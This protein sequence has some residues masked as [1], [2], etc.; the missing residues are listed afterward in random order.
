MPNVRHYLTPLDLSP[1]EREAVLQRASELKSSRQTP[2][3][4]RLRVGAL[5]FNPSLRTRISWEQAAWAVGGSCQTLNANSDNWAIEMDPN[6]VMDGTTVENIVEAARVLGRYFDIL[7]V[8]SFPGAGAWE[9]E[10]TEP[11]LQA[12]ARYSGTSVVSLEGAMHHP[13]QSLADLLTLRELFGPDLRGLPVVLTWASHP[14]PLPMA[15]PNSFA[16]QMA[17]AGCDLRIVRP[18]GYDLDPELMSHIRQAQSQSG[19]SLQITSD[20]ETGYRGAK[21]VYVK[22]W[23]K[24]GLWSDPVQ[25]REGRSALQDW[26][27]TP[28]WHQKTDQAKLMHCLPTRRNVEL[29][30]DLLDGPHSVVI[31]EAENRLWAQ[32]G[33]LDHLGK[34]LGL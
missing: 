21:A 5:F 17:L 30:G 13:C 12:F 31:D 27:Y 28:Q 15:V 29:S 20:R 34:E 2:P 19:G 33:L 26:C 32:A 3:I 18:E 23:G 22:S 10:R 1:D 25:E 7:G 4:R 9:V 24:L 16:L 11:A 14:K 6:A 8:R